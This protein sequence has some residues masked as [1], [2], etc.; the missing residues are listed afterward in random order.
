MW[1]KRSRLLTFNFSTKFFPLHK[2]FKDPQKIPGAGSRVLVS[3]LVRVLLLTRPE[4]DYS[5]IIK[6]I[7]H[8]FGTDYIDPTIKYGDIEDTDGIGNE[9]IQISQPVTVLAS[10]GKILREIYDDDWTANPPRGSLT[11]DQTNDHFKTAPQGNT[12]YIKYKYIDSL[13]CPNGDFKFGR[14]VNIVP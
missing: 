12:Y 1:T 7:D 11:L 8:A 10:G 14:T 6:T 2:K 5:L 4:L 3:S 9:I 13:N